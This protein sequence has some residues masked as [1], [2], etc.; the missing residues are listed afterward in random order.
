G[1]GRGGGRA[2]AEVDGVAGRAGRDERQ[3][4]PRRRRVLLPGHETEVG[5]ISHRGDL[6]V[7]ASERR[8]A[9]EPRAGLPVRLLEEGRLLMATRSFPPPSHP[10][11]S[12][13]LA[14]TPGSRGRERGNE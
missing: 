14:G 4:A 11:R 3:G 12:T 1:A 7:H 13:D 6:P 8:A 9:A 2:G 10:T 5:R